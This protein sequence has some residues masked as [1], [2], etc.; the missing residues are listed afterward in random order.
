MKLVR[1]REILKF[2][3]W[4]VQFPAHALPDDLIGLMLLYALHADSEPD[5]QSIYP[6]LSSNPALKTT[7]MSVAEKLK[8]EGRVEGRFEGRVVG[9]I[10]TL[11]EFL[12]LPIT[13]DTVLESLSKDALQEHH[14]ALRHEY[15]LRFK[16]G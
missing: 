13:S 9:K 14:D 16:R 3:A 12:D 15:G 2:F 10:Q 4:L 1:Q 7:T 8:I 6:I 5:A 11:E